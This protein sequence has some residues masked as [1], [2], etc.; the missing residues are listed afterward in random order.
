[1]STIGNIELAFGVLEFAFGTMQQP[2][3]FNPTIPFSISG[4]AM[5]FPGQSVLDQAIVTLQELSA[6][7]VQFLNAIS[8]A[9]LK[10]ATV[11]QRVA[12]DVSKC[13]FLNSNIAMQV[14]RTIIT[15]DSHF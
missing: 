11:F 13:L 5:S 15:I 10:W 4:Q 2:G 3:S 6:G 8:S 1:L 14:S 12:S 9:L 7:N